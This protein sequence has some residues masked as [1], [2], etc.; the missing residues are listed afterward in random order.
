MDPT[1][2]EANHELGSPLGAYGLHYDGQCRRGQGRWLEV[3]LV[4]IL[5]TKVAPSKPPNS[6]QRGDHKSIVWVTDHLGLLFH[7]AISQG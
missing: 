1:V 2:L 7:T 6:S 4:K 3:V 5:P